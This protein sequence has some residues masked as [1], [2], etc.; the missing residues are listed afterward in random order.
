M[1]LQILPGELGHHPPLEIVDETGPEHKLLPFRGLGVGGPGG[2]HNHPGIFA[3]AGRGDG[4][5]RG[6]GADNGQDIVLADKLLGGRGRRLGLVFIVF[7]EQFE[8]ALFTPYLQA[9]LLIHLGRQ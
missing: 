3:D 1:G 6:I 7:G 5:A 2:D 4:I 9:P 8:G